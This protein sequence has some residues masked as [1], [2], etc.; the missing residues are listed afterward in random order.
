MNFS[1]LYESPIK[2][3]KCG[4]DFCEKCLMDV[5]GN[6][7]QWSCPQC[8]KI[9]RCSISILSRNFSVE[10]FVEKFKKQAMTKSNNLFGTCERHNRAVEASK[11]FADPDLK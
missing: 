11:F 1:E 7:N 3:T 8:R 9:H 10:R 5:K 2:S 6:E 4:H